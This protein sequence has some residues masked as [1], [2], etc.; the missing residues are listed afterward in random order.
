MEHAKLL[1]NSVMRSVQD[2][3]T[4][5]D[6]TIGLEILR[7]YRRYLES[8]L[9]GFSDDDYIKGIMIVHDVQLRYTGDNPTIYGEDY[10]ALLK[11]LGMTAFNFSNHEQ[12]MAFRITF[13]NFANPF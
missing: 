10:V 7:W 13:F 5:Y 3:P 8:Y 12:L 6:G 1:S 9:L 11:V 2:G 4:E